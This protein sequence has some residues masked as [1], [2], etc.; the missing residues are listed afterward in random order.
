M[1]PTHAPPRRPVLIVFRSR[2]RTYD[3]RTIAQ[4]LRT[5]LTP[6]DYVALALVAHAWG[7]P[8]PELMALAMANEG[9]P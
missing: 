8:I 2:W 6:D 3:L 1:H 9:V 4:T 5:G 7:I